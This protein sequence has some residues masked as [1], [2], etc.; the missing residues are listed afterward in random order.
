GTRV[1]VRKAEMTVGLGPVAAGN[2]DVELGVAPHAVFRDVQTGRLR[3]GLDPDAPHSLHHPQRAE[4]RGERERA[5]GDE[6]ERLDAELMERAG[7]D[8]PTLA[9]RKI[10]RQSRYREDAGR[11]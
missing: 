3:L 1:S 10:G 8:E 11:E 9:G 2:R 5:Y 4:A 6:A 7:V